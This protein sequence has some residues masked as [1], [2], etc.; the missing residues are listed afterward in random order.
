MTHISLLTANEP[1]P[2]SEM[3]AGNK[4]YTLFNNYLNLYY[5]GSK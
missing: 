2:A 3:R 4:Y 5:Y 1:A